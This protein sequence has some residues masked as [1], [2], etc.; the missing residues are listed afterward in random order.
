MS[1]LAPTMGGAVGGSVTA[2]A[3][4]AATGSPDALLAV[5]GVLTLLV[6]VVLGP[7]V[8]SRRRERREAALAVLD[9][10]FGPR[11]QDPGAPS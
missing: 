7:A 10:I 3:I 4:S 9:R 11:Q 6:L 5:I 1:G 8:W 2:G